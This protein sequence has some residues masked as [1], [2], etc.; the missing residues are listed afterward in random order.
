MMSRIRIYVLMVGA[1]LAVTAELILAGVLHMVADD[2]QVSIA[3][4]GQ[5]VTVY[6]LAFAIGTPIVVTLTMRLDR[7]KVMLM[8]MFF[9]IVADVLALW[10]PAFS[11]LMASRILLGISGG[12]FTVVAMGAVSQLVSIDKIGSAMG[13]TRS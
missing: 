12:V 9:F 11:I 8:A 3:A 1:F 2:L 4:A 13:T 5:L 6:A 10:S 7:K